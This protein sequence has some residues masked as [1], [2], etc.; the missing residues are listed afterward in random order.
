MRNL[1]TFMNQHDYEWYA[2]GDTVVMLVWVKRPTN[3]WFVE[4]CRIHSVREAR[5]VMGY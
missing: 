3:D 4:T 1:I 2:D 5:E